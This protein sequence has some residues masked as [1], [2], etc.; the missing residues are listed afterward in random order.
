MLVLNEKDMKK[1]VSCAQVMDKVE[2]AYRICYCGDFY[3]PERPVITH[4]KNT[5]LFMPCFLPDCFGTKF[6]TIFPDNPGKG[7]PYIDGLMLL[8]DGESGK[9][10]AIMDASFLTAMRT[11]AAGGVGI[12]HFSRAECKS[13]GIIGA[14]R[15]GFYQAIFAKVARVGIEDIY[16]Y[17]AA[18]KDLGAYVEDLKRAMG[19]G[20]P[21]I[22]VCGNV[23]ELLEKSEIVITATPATSPVVPDDSDKLRG[24]CFVAIGSYKHEM[25]EIPDAIWGLVDN[26][27]T[28]LPFAMEESGDLTQPIEDGILQ[29]ERVKLIGQWL[30]QDS[31]PLPAQGQTTYFKSV[32]MGLLDICVARL[33]YENA[34]KMGLGQ[35]VDM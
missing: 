30:T 2:E 33:I 28:E 11:G 34:L 6:L 16:F 1:T 15:Q 26:V 7:Y 31:R 29:K 14:G 25:R 8:N 18:P 17:D 23:E 5:L 32:G 9:T 3:M 20:A 27:Y 10:K 35:E 19:D 4:G 12:R 21:K 13:A 24:K 22:H